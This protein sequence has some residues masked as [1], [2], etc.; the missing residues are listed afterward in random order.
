M[1]SMVMKHSLLPKSVP[2]DVQK[3]PDCHFARLAHKDYLLDDDLRGCLH[4]SMAAEP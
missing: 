2:D 4:D 1:P 3:F